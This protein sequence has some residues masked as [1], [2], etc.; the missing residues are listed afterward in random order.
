[1]DIDVSLCISILSSAVGWAKAHGTIP[2]A[3]N[4]SSLR[5]AHAFAG[6]DPTT[7]G[8]GAHTNDG[9]CVEFTACAPLPTL[10]DFITVRTRTAWSHVLRATAFRAN[11]RAVPPGCG[12]GR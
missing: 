1:M 9:I 2:Q 10:L 5:R 3:N 7:R 4:G 12:S 11:W 6:A 8:H